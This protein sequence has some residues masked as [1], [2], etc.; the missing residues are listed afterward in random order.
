MAKVKKFSGKKLDELYEVYDNAR[1]VAK[2]AENDKKDAGDEIKSLLGDVE[3]ASTTNYAVTYK[4]DQDREVE[5]FNEDIFQ[6][7]DPK[8]YKVYQDMLDKIKLICKK[9]TKKTTV[10]GARKLVVTAVAE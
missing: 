8:G 10:K 6:E 4:Y 3:E 5:T 2:E 7:N 1:R 9:Y